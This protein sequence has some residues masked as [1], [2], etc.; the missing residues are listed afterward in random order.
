MEYV[1]YAGGLIAV[2]LLIATRPGRYLTI[3]LVIGFI[4]LRFGD[5]VLPYN[6]SAYVSNACQRLSSREYSRI[7]AA[8][9]YVC[10]MMTRR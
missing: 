3:A 7:E 8:K 1:W 5:R 9:D 10:Q 4:A 6:P 2:V